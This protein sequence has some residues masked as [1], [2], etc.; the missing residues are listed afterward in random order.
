MCITINQ[1]AK[2]MKDPFVDES[3]YPVQAAEWIKQNLDLN[4]I[5][6]YNEYN[7][8]SYLLFQGIPVFIDSRCDLYMPEFNENVEVFRDFLGINGVNR[9]DIDEKIEEYGFTH[10][11]VS[12]GSR[13][14]AYLEDRPYEYKKIYPLNG[15]NDNFI[16]F[17]RIKKWKKI[18]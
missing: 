7:N 2:K 3:T 1:Y 5:K 17:E 6:L 9:S 8:G 18:F 14:K 13:F 11:I 10:F 16:I 15:E 4:E 12:R